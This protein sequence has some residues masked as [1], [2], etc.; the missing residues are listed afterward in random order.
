[1]AYAKEV[2]HDEA[3]SST[4]NGKAQRVIEMSMEKGISLST[5][6]EMVLPME[7]KPD[8]EKERIAEELLKQLQDA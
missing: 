6:E 8:E 3:R 7:G 1:M 4:G 5:L 2:I